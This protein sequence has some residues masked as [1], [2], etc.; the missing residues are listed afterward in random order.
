MLAGHMPFRRGIVVIIGCFILFSS[1]V[2][3]LALIE[4]VASDGPMEVAAAEAPPPLYRPPVVAPVPYDPYAGASVPNFSG[5]PD[6]NI[7]S[8]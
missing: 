2:I 8:Q 6:R 4:A 3:A 1:D 5:N 7:F